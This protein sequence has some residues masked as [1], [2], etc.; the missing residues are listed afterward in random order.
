MT[1]P[2]ALSAEQSVASAINRAAG[3]RPVPG[4]EVR[5]LIDGPDAYEAM[6]DVIGQATRW[7]HF[8]NY[9]IRSDAAGWRFAEALAARA[10]DGVHVRV[11]H[12][13][14][15]SFSTSRKYW[16][17]LREAGA[18]VRAFRPLRAIDLVGNLSRT[19]RK[20]VVADGARAV[21]GG[22][23]I[24][25]EWTGEDTDG[26]RPWRD[27]AVEIGG[28][29]SAVLDQAFARTWEVA[30]GML[31]D[32]DV[33]GRVTP[34]GEAEV[35]VIG[36]E[37]GRERTY[38]VIELM[39]AGSINRLWI[40]DAYLVAPPRLFQAL[41]DAARDGVDVRL[42]VPGLSDLP[43]VRNL[44]RIGYRDLLRSGVRIFEW[45]GPMLHAK[46]MVADGRWTRVGSSNL[47]P[48]S[49]LGNWELDVL[50]EDAALADAMERQFR[51]DVA[52]SR[53]VIRRPVRG[54]KRISAALPT[55][56][57]RENPEV[58]A[59]EHRPSRRERR[60]RAAL[61]LRAILSN[62]RRSIFLPLSAILI[63][64][65]ALF[66]ALP[67]IT[68]YAFGLLS[69]WLAVSAWR[70]AFRRRADK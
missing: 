32:T 40:T 47:N 70:E 68:A 37:P 33:A 57:Q 35:R 65:T 4:N 67:K 29:A 25:C 55:A 61:A 12:D 48:S 56:L 50:I 14:L 24:G 39:A 5:L 60:R 26:G 21:M 36:G 62:A 31:P 10:R 28:P 46:T 6:L 8:E 15:G 45:D 41:R 16:R 59:G 64:L 69:A 18:E 19:H 1:G 27:T 22:L 17:F 52:R 3:G 11:L 2:P 49:L 44:S 38:R 51:L 9:I 23:C 66:F 13:G 42:L 7:I 20:L 34:Q 43:L 63:S 30:G 53:E 54:P 58:A